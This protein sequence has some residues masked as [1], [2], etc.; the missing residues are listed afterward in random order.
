M[1]F[2]IIT[3]TYNR[4]SLLQRNIASVQTQSFHDFTHYIIDD[5]GDTVTADWMEYNPQRQTIF[6]KNPGNKGSN[7][8]KNQALETIFREHDTRDGYIIFLDDDDFLSDNALKELSEEI[9]REKKGWYMSLRCYKDGSQITRSVR[10]E[11]EYNYVEDYLL[12]TALHGDATH[13]ISTAILGDARFATDV[14]N[15]EEW[16][17]FLQVAQKSRIQFVSLSTTLSDGYLWDGLTSARTDIAFRRKMMLRMYQLVW[18][19]FPEI[20]RGKILLGVI[21]YL[22]GVWQA[23]FNIQRILTVAKK[24]VSTTFL[25]WFMQ[26]IYMTMRKFLDNPVSIFPF[27]KKYLYSRFIADSMIPRYEGY[28]FLDY[29]ATL[30]YAIEKN[31]TL[32]RFG[33][34][35]FDMLQWLWL[36]FDNWHQKYSK[37]LEKWIKKVLKEQDNRILLCFNPEFV[38][39][40]KSGFER[41]WIG[42]EWQLWINSKMY[43][44]K[45]LQKGRIYGSALLFHLRYNSSFDFQK[46]SRFLAPK[47]II[48]IVTKSS[49]FQ[50]CKLGVTTDFIE[51]PQSDAWDAYDEMKQSVLKLIEEKGYKK[52]NVLILGSASSATKVLAWDLQV[53][54]DIISWDT[55]QFFDIAARQ[56]QEL[57]DKK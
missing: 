4:L 1:H 30:D 22:P 8:S 49:R 54:H 56:I 25:K 38:F 21:Y 18:Q 55:G 48:I 43:L 10:W 6:M 45:Y 46:F 50:N 57:G 14:K 3:P 52:E 11:G 37:S 40:S 47:N 17:F 36:Y 31:V 9:S 15:G 24:Y 2:F 34:E 32:I 26:V 28:T 53:H 7:Y 16:I 39:K 13:S 33:D 12:G 44:Y 35:L 27:L 19:Y 5:S 41:E 42:S 29:A 51:S 23:A 20:F